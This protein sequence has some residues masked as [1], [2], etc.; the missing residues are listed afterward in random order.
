MRLYNVVKYANQ[1]K[2]S[3]LDFKKIINQLVI[4]K[5]NTFMKF[6]AESEN[7]PLGILV[8]SVDKPQK[9][10]REQLS[11]RKTFEGMDLRATFWWHCVFSLGKLIA[12]ARWIT[13]YMRNGLATCY[14][15]ADQNTVTQ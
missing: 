9:K 8:F 13:A 10:I 12:D 2:R 6:Y 7:V 3:V 5:K 11:N 15:E 4:R 14:G 1:Q